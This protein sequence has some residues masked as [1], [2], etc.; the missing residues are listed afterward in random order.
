MTFAAQD[1]VWALDPGTGRLSCLL[2]SRH[3]EPFLW[4]PQADRV[5]LGGLR[6]AG[7]RDAPSYP[8]SNVRPSIADW[9]H[10]VGL[11]VVYTVAGGSHPLKFFMDT[12][13]T[14]TLTDLP[15]GHYLG[16]AYHPTGLALGFIIERGGTQSIWLSTNEG[17]QAKRLVFTKTATTFSDLTF[18]ADGQD[19]IYMAHHREGYSH[20]HSID[21]AKPDTI[22]SLWKG[23]V[24][25][26]VRTVEPSP[27]DQLFAVTEGTTCEEDHAALLIGNAGDERPL[28]PDV[29]GPTS[30]LG[31]IDAV[32]VLVGAGG[33]GTPMSVYEVPVVQSTPAQL[34]VSGV[35]V[36][37]SR[38]PAPST[39][40]SLPRE[41]LLDT[42]SG[43]G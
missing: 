10:P 1:R 34:L 24:G 18:S 22:N 43:V 9:G 42:G 40:A 8:P 39:P 23:P 13:E 6:V 31:W 14:E 37:A 17:Q 27:D 26:Y 25:E 33:C 7:W 3:P 16:V 5:L 4:G 20:L 19:L 21:L 15:S 30:V 41:V 11:A 2:T 28:L 32:P 35:S 36:A 38:A 29:D 12:G